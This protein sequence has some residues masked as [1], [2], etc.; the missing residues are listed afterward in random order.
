MCVFAKLRMPPAEIGRFHCWNSGMSAFFCEGRSERFTW[1][2]ALLALALALGLGWQLLS[3]L[4][5]E[6]PVAT[7]EAATDRIDIFFVLCIDEVRDIFYGV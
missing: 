1:G 6:S 7:L 3:L 5:T 4:G 2:A